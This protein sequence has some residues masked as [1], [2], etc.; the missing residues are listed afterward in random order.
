MQEWFRGMGCL[1]NSN[2]MASQTA[3]T[4]GGLRR[5]S[6]A[7]VLVASTCGLIERLRVQ[8]K[9]SVSQRACAHEGDQ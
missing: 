5:G 2:I 7:A 3:L 4:V 9:P 8:Q 6:F 1:G